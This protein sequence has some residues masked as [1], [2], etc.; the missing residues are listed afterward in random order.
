VSLDLLLSAIRLASQPPKDSLIHSHQTGPTS[1]P[2]PAWRHQRSVRLLPISNRYFIHFIACCIRRLAN[3]PQ[4]CLGITLK[5][6]TPIRS[7]ASFEPRPTCTCAASLPPQP[8][9]LP[10][11]VALP[12]RL[13]ILLLTSSPS[14][15]QVQCCRLVETYVSWPGIL[16]MTR[17]TCKRPAHTYICA[18]RHFPNLRL[19]IPNPASL[20]S[21]LLL[22]QL[23]CP[24]SSLSLTDSPSE[25]SITQLA[26]SCLESHQ[27][28]CLI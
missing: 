2:V 5:Q 17:A 22:P 6:Q 27:Q 28:S 26:R 13:P 3:D 23:L 25:R 15:V 19:V 20:L 8:H 7:G 1:G 11:V 16:P 21:A 4:R 12:A 9:R 10:K 14:L 24:P 18:S